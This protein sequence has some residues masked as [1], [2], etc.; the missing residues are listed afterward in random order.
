M[1]A[2]TQII[3]SAKDLASDT[4]RRVGLASQGLISIFERTAGLVPFA[5]AGLGAFGVKQL[6]EH[7]VEY[8]DQAGKMA[9]KTG[10]TTQ[11]YTE[12]AYAAMLADVPTETMAKGL[13]RLSKNMVAAAD[14]SGDAFDAFHTMG[15]SVK[16]GAG[17]L[18]SADTVISEL[19]E[20]FGGYEDGAAKVALAMALFGRGGAEMIP[21]LNRGAGEL[22]NMREEA[23]KMGLTFGEEVARNAEEVNDNFKRLHS[24]TEALKTLLVTGMLP[25]LLDTSEYFLHLSGSASQFRSYLDDIEKAARGTIYVMIGLKNAADIVA[26]SWYYGLS[27][28]AWVAEGE[29]GKAWGEIKKIHTSALEDLRDTEKAYEDIW[30]GLRDTRGN[31]SGLRSSGNKKGVQGKTQAP[32]IAKPDGGDGASTLKTLMQDAMKAEQALAEVHGSYMELTLTLAGDTYGATLM[33][34]QAEYDKANLETL[35]E[36]QKIQD[37]RKVLASKNKLTPE[38]AGLLDRQ[39]MAVLGKM[40]WQPFVQAEKDTLAQIQNDLEKMAADASHLTVMADLTGQGVWEAKAKAINAKYDDLVRKKSGDTPELNKYRDDMEAERAAALARAGQDKAK[41]LASQRAELAQ[42]T[43]NTREYYQAQAEVLSIERDL[44]QTT[45][46]RALK[47]QQLADVM[48]KANGDWVDASKRALQDYSASAR[49]TW[50]NVNRFATSAAQNM[51]DAMVES[52]M[53]TENAWTNALKAI[54]KELIRVMIRQSAMGRATEMLGGAISGGLADL[55]GFGGSRS[56]GTELTSFDLQEDFINTRASGGPVSPGMYLVGE[57][58][59]E[60]LNM[61]GSGYVYT[62][63]QTASML[64]GGSPVSVVIQN[65]YDFRGADSGTEARLRRYVDETSRQTVKDATAAVE[66]KA[67]RGGSYAKS[68]AGRPQ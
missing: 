8:M 12:Y 36:F 19:A 18:K 46:E 62:A 49:D 58:G 14:G 50:S 47:E 28:A 51:E 42:L 13:A 9:Q 55:F 2:E 41:A 16:D 32:I 60:L 33:K 65:S 11:A 4:F 3:I 64:G 5:G 26:Y 40:Y 52:A 35:K 59:P 20:K 66:A 57:Q 38:A 54:E 15:I 6:I 63:D 48:A 61:G 27:A 44:A 43:G 7:Q 30:L 1:V 10:L 67:R 21:L 56:G 24:R 31:E 17:Q 29:F 68:L 23:R 34:N 37:E 53:G 22:A 39:Q 45:E 25:A